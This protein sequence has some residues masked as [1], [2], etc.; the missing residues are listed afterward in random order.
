VLIPSPGWYKFNI[1]CLA[2]VGDKGKRRVWV[3]C[4]S[5]GRRIVDRVERSV[6]RIGGRPVRLGVLRLG[7]EGE[8]EGK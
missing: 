8:V 4:G 3:C 6:W 7:E 5:V 2:L 1:A